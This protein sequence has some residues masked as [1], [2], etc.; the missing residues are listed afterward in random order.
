[1]QKPSADDEIPGQASLLPMLDGARRESAASGQEQS[2]A[3]QQRMAFVLS[4]RENGIA[5]VA[6]LR[7]LETIPRE[8]F[9]PHH[10]AD[11]AWRDIALPIAC[12]QTMP[13]PFAV[14]R[15]MAA[16]ELEPQHRV[17]EIGAGSGYATSI[18]ARLAG[19]VVS[20]ER[21]RSL[22]RAAQ[23]RIESLGLRNANVRWADGFDLP[24]DMGQF[25]RIIIDTAINELPRALSAAFAPG[26]LAIFARRTD[27]GG[28]GDGL[29]SLRRT[30]SGF[31]EDFLF[32]GRFPAA[33]A[34]RSEQL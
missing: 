17:L 29:Y 25:D 16:L 31:V 18:V 14:A 33:L 22:A 20:F 19:E 21:F 12:G 10:F 24:A 8:I 15:M 34:G 4:L 7:A 13:K 30:P 3:D 26:G 32:A 23:S 28:A 27:M 9:V 6:L 2:P 1:M 11:L 5:D